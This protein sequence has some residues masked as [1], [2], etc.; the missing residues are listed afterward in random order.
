MAYE[1]QDN[2]GSLFKNDKR[3]KD[4]HANARGSAMIDGIAYWVDAWTNEK[5]GAK[6]QSLKFKKKDNQERVPAARP[7]PG[8]APS[9]RLADMDSDIPF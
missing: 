3:E 5:N 1:H 7:A 8:I 9:Q 6:Y 2:T 4:T